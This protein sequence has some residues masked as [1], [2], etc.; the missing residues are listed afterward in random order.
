[1]T[2]RA[3]TGFTLIE[4]LVVMTIIGLL[5]TLAVPRYFNTL[6]K[7]KEVVLK[8]DLAT[9]RSS[10]DKYY[11]D[12]GKYPDSLDELVSQKYLRSIPV[13]PITDSRTTWLIV[14]PEQADLGGVFDVHSGAPG[15]AADGTPYQQW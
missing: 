10:L 13:D 2:Q 6:A 12:K 3:K 9:M 7:S 14:P 11:G 4:L 8:D 5:A 1:M 15:A